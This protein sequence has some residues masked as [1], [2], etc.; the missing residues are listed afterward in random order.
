M[1]NYKK[2]YLKYKVKYL[3][4]KKN[5]NNSQEGG[6]NPLE[7]VYYKGREILGVASNVEGIRTEALTFYEEQL[8]TTNEKII[9]TENKL[10]DLN[11]LL[12]YNIN[13]REELL[14]D[15]PELYKIRYD[16]LELLEEQYNKDLDNTLNE[17]NI[18]N[19]KKTYNDKKKELTKKLEYELFIRKKTHESSLQLSENTIEHLKEEIELK[20]KQLNDFR[21]NIVRFENTIKEITVYLEGP[22]D[23]T[24]LIEELERKAAI[25]RGEV[26]E[27]DLNEDK[28]EDKN[29]KNEMDDEEPRQL[30]N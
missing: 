10:K 13:V 2:K 8:K 16:E 24:P 6:S 19:I 12:L 29:K 28:N 17:T 4:E 20:E 26:V 25:L 7:W 11:E 18:A 5:Q 3:S 21:E 30:L 9:E 22:E 1:V 14:N 15:S 27:V 23:D